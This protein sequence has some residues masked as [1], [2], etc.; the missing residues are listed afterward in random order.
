MEINKQTSVWHIHSAFTLKTHSVFERIGFNLRIV[1]MG[2]LYFSLAFLSVCHCH[3]IR[4]LWGKNSWW[5][6]W[7]VKH[8]KYWWWFLLVYFLYK[9]YT[10]HFTLLK[11]GK[12]CIWQFLLLWVTLSIFKMSASAVWK[13][14]EIIPSAVEY[15]VDC[16]VCM[17]LFLIR[18]SEVC[19]CS[20]VFCKWEGFIFTCLYQVWFF[21]FL[22]FVCLD[23][24]SRLKS[25]CIISGKQ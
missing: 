3:L 20:N 2:G 24:S 11:L 13:Y 22:L 12:K 18:F 25:C 23:I 15:C 21:F 17:I 16:V 6:G 19:K 14:L 10:L 1:L 5:Q 4:K 8:R 7:W 9:T